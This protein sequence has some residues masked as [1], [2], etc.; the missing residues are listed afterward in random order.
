[1][2]DD[3]ITDLTEDEESSGSAGKENQ[4]KQKAPKAPKEPKEP[5]EKKGKDKK[6]SKE[7]GEDAEKKGGAGGIIIIMILV[8]V[9][10][11]GGFGAA[12]Y[13]NVL[14][15]RSIVAN[16]V[17]DPLIKLVIWLDPGFS[18]IDDRMRA[19]SASRD[20][21]HAEKEAELE[22]RDEEVTLREDSINSREAQL[23]R[24]ERELDSREAQII[25][26]YE[27]TVPIYRRDMTEQEQEDMESLSRTYSQMSPSDAAERL[28]RL[29]DPRD[30]A[31]ILYFMMERPRAAILAAMNP[32]Y[33]A[34]ITEIL[35]YS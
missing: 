4:K 22:E 6:D 26:M 28:A 9:I 2:A 29:Y 19:E 34:E 33:A 35:L 3:D 32:T 5:K 8:L 14:G 24:R 30:V 25:A 17:N 20:K 16:A 23:D 12:M 21:R 10:L 7:T 31:A 27:R 15:A 13:F 11:I 18:S 1:L